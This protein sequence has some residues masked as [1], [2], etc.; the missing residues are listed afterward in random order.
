ME[1]SIFIARIATVIYLSIAVGLLFNGNYYK[2]EFGKLLDNSAYLIL[3]G[4]MAIIIGS[5]I[6]KYHNFWVKDWTILV[7]II[8]WI[9]LVKGALLLA[10]PKIFFFFKPMLKSESL[11]KFVTLMVIVLGLVFGYFGFFS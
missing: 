6:V 11:N 4:M 3:G 7:T 8:G 9:A 10:F 2:K 1:T 5:L